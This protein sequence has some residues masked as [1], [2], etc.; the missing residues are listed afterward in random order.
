MNKKK[1]EKKEWHVSNNIRK[2]LVR[3]EKEWSIH[4]G[5]R[6]LATLKSLII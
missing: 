3:F 4:G 2:R 6:V 5:F 1:K